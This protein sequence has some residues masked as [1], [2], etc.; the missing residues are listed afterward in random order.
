MKKTAAFSL[1]EVLVFISILSL[2]FVVAML[3]V[4]TSL[5]NM[6]ISE[7]KILATRYA[8][9]AIEWIGSQKEELGWDLFSGKAAGSPY[10]LNNNILSWTS[11]VCT[12]TLGNPAFFKREV[13]VTNSGS[14]VIQVNTAVTVKWIETGGIEYQVPINKVYRAWE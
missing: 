3:V 8:E 7:H 9:E 10:C 14:P 2:F 1:V 11:G 5:R 6:K 13:A 12:Y 4:T